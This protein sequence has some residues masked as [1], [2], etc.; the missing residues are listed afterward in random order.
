MDINENTSSE[1]DQN[2]DYTDREDS[3]FEVYNEPNLLTEGDL[4]DLLRDLNL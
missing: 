2:E 3:S 4:N 1:E